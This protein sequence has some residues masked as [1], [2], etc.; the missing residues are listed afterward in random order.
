VVKY[1]VEE[2]FRPQ[3]AS[4]VFVRFKSDADAAK[5]TSPSE[6]LNIVAGCSVR[7]QPAK[8]C[9]AEISKWRR[10]LL[11]QHGGAADIGC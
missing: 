10:E 3:G 5:C 4:F 8:Q 7:V 9:S 2:V 11:G 1:Q 6:G